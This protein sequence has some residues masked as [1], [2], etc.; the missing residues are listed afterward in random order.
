MRKTEWILFLSVCFLM[1]N[2]DPDAAALKWD[3]TRCYTAVLIR[4]QACM[5]TWIQVHCLT[6]SSGSG[7]GTTAQ[8]T[9]HE[10]PTASAGT[11][12]NREENNWENGFKSCERFDFCQTFHAF[13]AKSKMHYPW[14][15]TNQAAGTLQSSSAFTCLLKRWEVCF[16]ITIKKK[17]PVNVS[18]LWVVTLTERCYCLLVDI[19]RLPSPENTCLTV[20]LPVR[21]LDPPSLFSTLTVWN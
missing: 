20:C 18:R 19:L 10:A 1:F 4:R 15:V 5:H 8:P 7:W 11:G 2:A 12:R 16:M 17:N 21:S 13:L 6:H 3:E 14:A 9:S